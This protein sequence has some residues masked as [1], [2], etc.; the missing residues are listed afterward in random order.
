MVSVPVVST[1]DVGLPESMP[2]K[3]DE[4]IATLAGPP[5]D[6]PSM[7]EAKSMKNAPPPVV[8][9]TTPKT[10]K[11]ISVSATT[12]IGMPMRLSRP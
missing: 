2:K 12:C 4:M 9:S 11:P 10:R 5:R 1:F 8:A 7:A 3:P 6:V